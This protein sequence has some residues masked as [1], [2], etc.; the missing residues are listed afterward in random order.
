MYNTVPTNAPHDIYCQWTKLKQQQHKYFTICSLC[1]HLP[2]T[3]NT[4]ERMQPNSLRKMAAINLRLHW[5]IKG[6]VCEC[7]LASSDE[8]LEAS[9]DR[10]SYVHQDTHQGVPTSLWGSLLCYDQHDYY[11][12]NEETGERRERGV[13]PEKEILIEGSQEFVCTA[14]CT[15]NSLFLL[16]A[17]ISKQTYLHCNSLPPLQC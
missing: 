11:A 15:N 1:T 14:C 5:I 13:K 16:S 17:H 10:S 3:V 12:R 7:M 8:R 6:E 2:L 4:I 9:C